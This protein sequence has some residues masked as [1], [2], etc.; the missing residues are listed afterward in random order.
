MPGALHEDVVSTF[1]QGFGSACAGLPSDIHSKIHINTG[2]DFDGFEGRYAG[3]EKIADVGIQVCNINDKPEMRLV[4]EVGFSETYEDMVRDARL[5]LEGTSTVST[6][7]LV[8]LRESPKYA[9]PTSNLDPDQ[10]DYPSVTVMEDYLFGP[11]YAGQVYGPVVFSAFTWFGRLSSA[12]VETW[13]RDPT[14][15]LAVLDGNRMVSS[16]PF[17]ENMPDSNT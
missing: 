11:D 6:A 13:R 4:V 3:S 9:C 10:F 8:Q 15:G 12:S 17:L 7:V 1:I 2:L 16:N 5:W 14:S